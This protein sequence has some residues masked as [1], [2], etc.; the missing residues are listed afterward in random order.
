VKRCSRTLQASR[1]E[2]LDIAQRVSG[3]DLASFALHTTLASM[4]GTTLVG[5]YVI[6]VCQSSQQRW[7]VPGRVLE[8]LPHEELAVPVTLRITV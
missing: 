5:D 7:W 1:G 4:L 6:Q 3:R 2:D 8:P